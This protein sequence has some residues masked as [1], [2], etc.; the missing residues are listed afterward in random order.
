MRTIQLQMLKSMCPNV[1]KEKPFRPPLPKRLPKQL[2]SKY[3]VHI[4]FK[5]DY[6]YFY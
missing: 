5:N 6:N 3:F 2:K 1:K 4:F